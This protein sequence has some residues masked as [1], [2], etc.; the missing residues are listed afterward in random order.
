MPTNLTRIIGIAVFTVGLALA[1]A[2]LSP[3]PAEAAAAKSACRVTNYYSYAGAQGC[4]TSWR[5]RI[6]CAPTDRNAYL[7]YSPWSRG[8]DWAGAYCEGNTRRISTVIERR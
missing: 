5:V 7:A 3:A 2:A 4:G 6:T 1:P 8:N